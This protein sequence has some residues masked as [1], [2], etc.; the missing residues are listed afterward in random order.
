MEPNPFARAAEML[1]GASV[2]LERTRDERDKLHTMLALVRVELRQIRQELNELRELATAKA[3][4]EPDGLR[5]VA[6]K[7][8][9]LKA[10]IA[11][12]EATIRTLAS[13]RDDWK[14]CA[15]RAHINLLRTRNGDLYA[16]PCT[17]KHTVVRGIVS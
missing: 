11:R 14:R 7:E 10:E 13:E 15:I 16:Q 4:G 3:R 12:L 5:V 8:S 1:R 9:G 17:R 6:A 2:D